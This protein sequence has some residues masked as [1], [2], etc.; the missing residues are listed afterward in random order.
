MARATAAL[1]ERGERG[2]GRGRGR[3]G[4]PPRRNVRPAV[5]RAG[6]AAERIANLFDENNA[7]ALA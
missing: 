7:M 1:A 4:R 5:G 2:R 3:G 6:Q